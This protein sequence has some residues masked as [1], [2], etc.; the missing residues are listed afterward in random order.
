MTRQVH[1]KTRSPE[2]KRDERKRRIG[3]V[4][5]FSNGKPKL[6]LTFDPET[7]QEV[8]RLEYYS[9]GRIKKTTLRKANG[10]ISSIT[11]FRNDE[12]NSTIVE[13]TKRIQQLNLG[14]SGPTE[15]WASIFVAMLKTSRSSRNSLMKTERWNDISRATIMAIL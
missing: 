1:T 5:Y 6:E 9:S 15:K 2:T 13:T 4:E 12:E 14:L 3:Y 8:S 7:E 11:T 10:A